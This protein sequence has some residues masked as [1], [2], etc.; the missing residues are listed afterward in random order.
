MQTTYRPGQWY[1]IV[2]PGALVALP[3]DVPGDVVAGLWERLPG[4]KTLATVVDVLT[5]HAGGSFAALPSFAAAVAEGSDVRLALRGDVSA[6]VLDAAGDTHDLT[7]VDVTTWSER[8]ISGASRIELTV[9]PADSD[10]ALPVQSGVVRSAGAS[11]E[12]ESGDADP[13]GGALG[14]T[15]VVA[16]ATAADESLPEAIAAVPVPVDA[17]QRELESQIESVLAAEV[18]SGVEPDVPEQPDEIADQDATDIEQPE[19]DAAPVPAPDAATEAIDVPDASDDEPALAPEATLGANGETLVS[20]DDDFDQLW[21]AT[22]H[23]VPGPPAPPAPP[24]PVV[25]PA[26]LSGDHDGATISAAE[27]RALRQQPPAGD[28]APTA[29]LPVSDAASAGR[30]RVS[31]GQVVALDRTVI[32]GR[33]PRSTRASGANLPH[34]VA[35]ESPQQDISRSHLEVR[36]EGDTVVVIDLHTTNGSTLLRPGADPMRLHPGEQTLVL[37]GDVVDLGDGVTVA[38]EDLP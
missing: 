19:P 11:A 18:M 22:V 9:E 4:Q 24:A 32:I 27:L 21:G 35:V 23:S 29:V 36:P 31:T 26:A 16:A 7:G 1:L 10:A 6:Q 20:E 25:A 3:P 14:P 28:D 37:S 12:L 38:F 33:R 15:P 30:I 13:L 8:F 5:T 2:I 17:S 34:L